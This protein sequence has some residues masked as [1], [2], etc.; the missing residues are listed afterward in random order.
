[1]HDP[2]IKI[3]TQI[4]GYTPPKNRRKRKEGP[5]CCICGKKTYRY[6]CNKPLCSTCQ[7]EHG[8]NIWNEAFPDNI[9]LDYNQYDEE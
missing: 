3:P 1:M 7:S 8:I 9:K 5:F 4:E 6:L 2:H